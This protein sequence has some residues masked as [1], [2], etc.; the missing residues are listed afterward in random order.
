VAAIQKDDLAAI[1]TN[2]RDCAANSEKVAVSK[3]LQQ[4]ADFLGVLVCNERREIA[5]GIITHWT[6][7]LTGVRLHGVLGGENEVLH[8]FSRLASGL[9]GLDGKECAATKDLSDETKARLRRF[10]STPIPAN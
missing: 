3:Y 1:D 7:P 5:D 8:Y 6:M 4:H 9:L 2:W 10:A